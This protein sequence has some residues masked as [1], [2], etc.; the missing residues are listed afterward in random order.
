MAAGAVVLAGAFGNAPLIWAQ[1]NQDAAPAGEAEQQLTRASAQIQKVTNRSIQIVRSAHFQAVG[2][3]SEAFM[4]IT[5][6]DCELIAQDY[7][8]HFRAKG[9]DVK[10]PERLLTLVVFVDERP[11]KIFTKGVPNAVAGLY[12][13]TEN[14]LVLFDYRNISAPVE[15]P[16]YQA[17]MSVLAHEAT[18]LLA[19][20]T[21]LLNRHGDVPRAITEG[22]GTYGEVRKLHGRSQPG[23]INSSRLDDLA[24]I[25]RRVDWV[26]VADLL[27]DDKTG[28]TSTTDRVLLSYA[29]SWLLVYY[30]MTTPSRL[31]QFRGYLKTIFTRSDAKHRREDAEANFGS[32]DRLDR[33]LRQ[34]AIRLQQRRWH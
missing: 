21:G 3:A 6:N 24:H 15:R 13:R 26:K 23:G 18:H 9:F 19:Y 11:F 7:L 32:L 16:G 34:E 29:Q 33:D 10:V 31:P 30:L 28:F 27:A 25:Q 4:K 1:A 5:L 8:E 12:R 20:N 22:L 14:W 17:N 2:D